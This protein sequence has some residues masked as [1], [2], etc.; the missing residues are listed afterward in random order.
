MV[1]IPMDGGRLPQGLGYRSDPA[2]TT[3]A[4][5]LEGAGTSQIPDLPQGEPSPTSAV[6]LE[7]KSGELNPL[8]SRLISDLHKDGWL[9]YDKP[10]VASSND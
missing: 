3:D 4:A 10:H 1:D 6:S 2:P 5:S 7:T 8:G 9:D